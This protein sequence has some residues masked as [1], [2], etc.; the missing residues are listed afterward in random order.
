M[1]R[2]KSQKISI[3]VQALGLSFLTCKLGIIPRLRAVTSA[4]LKAQLLVR[5]HQNHS[6]YV[7]YFHPASS[8]A[9]ANVGLSRPLPAGSPGETLNSC[10]KL[11]DIFFPF[12]HC[13]DL[14]DGTWWNQSHLASLLEKGTTQWSSFPYSILTKGQQNVVPGIFLVLCRKV[15]GIICFQLLLTMRKKFKAKYINWLMLQV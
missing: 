12:H 1:E 2:L 11:G 8:R 9:S 3:G 15:S 10:R 6:D 14:R 13:A 7:C 4:C 5:S